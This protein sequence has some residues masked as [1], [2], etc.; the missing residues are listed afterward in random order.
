MS[1]GLNT[2]RQTPPE[3][4]PSLYI[5]VPCMVHESRALRAAVGAR[6]RAE[7]PRAARPR[8]GGACGSA[9]PEPHVLPPSL[10]VVLS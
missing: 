2:Q 6:P 8:H 1:A 7:H 10:F 4:L 9:L 3:V 5:H